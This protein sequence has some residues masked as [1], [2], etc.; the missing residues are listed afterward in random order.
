[1]RA[2]YI[3]APIFEI[4]LSGLISPSGGQISWIQASSNRL[5]VFANINEMR[6]VSLLHLDG[7]FVGEY[8]PW[9]E[10]VWP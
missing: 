10:L 8:V 3:N 4:F 5:L 9:F 1:M 7:C 6:N 2:S